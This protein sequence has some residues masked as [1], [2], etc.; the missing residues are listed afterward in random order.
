MLAEPLRDTEGKIREVFFI[1]VEYTFANQY[2]RRTR[3]LL[4]KRI[5]EALNRQN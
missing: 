4:R 3:I 2:E 1:G 5:E